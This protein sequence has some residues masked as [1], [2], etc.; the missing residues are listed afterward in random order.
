[1]SNEYT[2]PPFLTCHTFL[3]ATDS[4]IKSF[5]IPSS[6]RCGSTALIDPDTPNVD[7][8]AGLV[9]CIVNGAKAAAMTNAQSL[10]QALLKSKID[11]Q[12][13]KNPMARKVYE[14][15]LAQE[16]LAESSIAAVVSVQPAAS[17]QMVLRPRAREPQQDV[18]KETRC[19]RCCRR[20]QAAS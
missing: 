1:M 4:F 16:E 14:S 18:T 11:S 20:N 10:R 3:S 19:S 8:P 5:P 15:L 2:L 13:V 7:Y 6:V 17:H 12:D 9:D